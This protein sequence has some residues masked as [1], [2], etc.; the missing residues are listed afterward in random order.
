MHW[1]V[2]CIH[3]EVFSKSIMLTLLF[4][5]DKSLDLMYRAPVLPSRNPRRVGWFLGTPQN[6]LTASEKMVRYDWTKK[7]TEYFEVI[8][9]EKSNNLS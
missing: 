1:F 6:Q 5:I 3:F 7:E 9:K 8:K 4:C 2:K